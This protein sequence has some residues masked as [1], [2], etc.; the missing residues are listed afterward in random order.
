MGT[1]PLSPAVLPQIGPCLYRSKILQKIK[2]KN[3]RA[4]CSLPPWLVDHPFVSVVL[5]VC[6]FHILVTLQQHHLDKTTRHSAG[7]N[8][9]QKRESLQE[10]HELYLPSFHWLSKTVG[11]PGVTRTTVRSNLSNTDT[12][13]T[14][15]SV[16]I[17]EVTM[18]TSLLRPH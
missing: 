11:P 18:I 9:N 3:K 12:E 1:E 10:R 14:E 13:G 6:V 2:L 16:R 17:G 4:S 8:S 15:R 7:L 5:V